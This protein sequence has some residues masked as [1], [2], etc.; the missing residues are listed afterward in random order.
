MVLTALARCP[1][2]GYE[3]NPQYRFCG[4]CGV[5]LKPAAVPVGTTA[6]SKPTPRNTAP[7]SVGGYSILGLSKEEGSSH[8]EPA[9]P[10]SQDPSRSESLR[11]RSVNIVPN[12]EEPQDTLLNR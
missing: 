10:R 2:C 6:E 8:P 12:D 11:I 5:A 7:H 9:P 3:N 1:G 4:M